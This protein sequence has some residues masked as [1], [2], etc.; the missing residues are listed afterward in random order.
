MREVVI[1]VAGLIN[2]Q[3]SDQKPS[4]GTC[5]TTE[6]DGVLVASAFH[7]LDKVHR[8][9]A[10]LHAL[11]KAIEAIPAGT[12]QVT[13]VCR[14]AHLIRLGSAGDLPLNHRRQWREIRLRLASYTVIWKVASGSDER[15]AALIRCLRALLADHS[16]AGPKLASPPRRR[17][18]A[19]IGQQSENSLSTDASVRYHNVIDKLDASVED[20]ILPWLKASAA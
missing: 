19:V 14:Y 3:T 5:F 11:R 20:N 4:I 7:A 2:E 18:E 15:Q 16:L 17:R 8:S 6:S 9:R 10:L 1:H 13:I 12:E